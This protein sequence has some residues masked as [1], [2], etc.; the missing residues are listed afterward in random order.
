M[1]D[2]QSRLE[3]LHHLSCTQQLTDAE[4]E[5]YISL[6][7][8][9]ELESMMK[10]SWE[11]TTDDDAFPM[12]KRRQLAGAILSR[13]PQETRRRGIIPVIAR[14][15]FAAAAS[16]AV[17]LT[18]GAYFIFKPASPVSVKPLIADIAPGAN[19]AILTL[20]DGSR[21]VLDSLGDG[22]VAKQK[23]SDAVIKNGH[24]AYQSYN[25]LAPESAI[26]YNT[27][28]TPRGRQFHMV[29]PDGTQV[30]LNAATSVRYPVAFTGN[31][32][33]VEVTGE[34]YFD[35]AQDKSKPFS[36]RFLSS[37]EGGRQGIVQALGTAFNVCA[38]HDDPAAKITLLEGKVRVSPSPAGNRNEILTPGQ[39]AAI[40]Y[41]KSQN[42]GMTVQ[43]ADTGRVMAWKNGML[44]LHNMGLAEVMKQISR[45][46]NIDVVYE[47]N[48][49]EITFWGE[50]SRSE[51]LS[52]VLSFMAESG[53]KFIIEDG[54]KKIVVRKQ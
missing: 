5:E 17:V 28:T 9:R 18:A 16:V 52:T 26:V 54:G 51:N 50:I 45:W 46:Y 47:G 12:E 42:A 39:Q 48:I 2:S 41:G 29:L 7:E 38:Y 40:F 13:Y 25:N 19:G 14:W 21:V 1:E 22:L 4:S 37:A 24:L 44:N 36:V 32:R 34:A 10:K 35:V 15:K 33:I 23:G 11:K 27:M 31:E 20:G 43:T 30:W 49:P 6:L 53:V 8:Q 3:Y